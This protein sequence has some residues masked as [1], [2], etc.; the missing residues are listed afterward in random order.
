MKGRIKSFPNFF[1]TSVNQ[2]KSNQNQQ[3]LS[4]TPIVYTEVILTWE[5]SEFVN[6]KG[7]NPAIMGNPINMYRGV[8]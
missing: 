8:Q 3:P 5:V 4:Q 2:N 1:Y 6:Q 7:T